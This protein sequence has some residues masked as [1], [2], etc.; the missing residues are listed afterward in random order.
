[1]WS[2]LYQTVINRLYHFYELCSGIENNDNDTNG[3]RGGR[4]GRNIDRIKRQI[5]L[6]EIREMV[7]Q[8]RKDLGQLTLLSSN[9][10]KLLQRDMSDSFAELSKELAHNFS[11]TIMLY[12]SYLETG[13]PM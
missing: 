12:L 13:S 7:E 5:D 1:M 4:R 6:N 3:E 2:E 10:K 8:Q 11:L 9:L